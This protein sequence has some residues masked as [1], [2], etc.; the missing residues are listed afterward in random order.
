[1]TIG[2][3]DLTGRVFER[4]TVKERYPERD[5]NNHIQWLCL[6]SCGNT[7]IVTSSRLT[8]GNTR[9]CG[10]LFMETRTKHGASYTPEYRSWIAIKDRCYNTKNKHYHRYGGRGITM[11][12][13]FRDNFE[14]FLNDVGPR[15]SKKHSIDRIE[16]D[17]GY[18]PGNCRWATKTEQANNR[19]S[20]IR[21]EFEGITK[22]L[23][24]WC[25]YFSLDYYL[26]HHRLTVNLWPFEKAMGLFETT[27][28]D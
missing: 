16:N 21:I 6:C 7:L 14:A 13:E 4:L 24:E 22:T 25:R 26:V 12:E 20:N 2:G 10:C 28:G 19:E 5:R 11:S 17:K 8:S 15:P 9:S 3:V 27:E 18:Q 1:M 23:A